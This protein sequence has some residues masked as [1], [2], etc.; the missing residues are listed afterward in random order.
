VRQRSRSILITRKQINTT[1]TTVS[2]LS[3]G[4]WVKQLYTHTH[5]H[6]HTH[7]H[8]HTADNGPVEDKAIPCKEA[9]ISFQRGDILQVMCQDDAT[10]WQA[11][12]HSDTNPRAGLIPS[13]QFQERG[14]SLSI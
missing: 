11:R 6:T 13:K 4:A 2:Q 9:G 12:H 10:W 3:Q 1:H 14:G 7:R 8:T 5:T